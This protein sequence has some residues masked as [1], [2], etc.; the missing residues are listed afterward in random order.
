MAE[1][2]IVIDG[3]EFSFENGETILQ[4]AE[5]NGIFIPT[6]CYLKTGATP[7]GAC[8]VCLV[9][10]KGARSLMAACTVPA[11]PNMVVRT[12]SP[13]V[14]KARRMNLELLLASGQHNCLAQDQ[15]ADSWTDFQLKALKDTEHKDL[16]PAYGIC[17]LQDFAVRYRVRTTHF[18]PSETPF[19][20]ENV[21][22]FIVR[23]FSRCVLCG[24]CV[25]ACNEV[26]VNNAISYGY[27]GSASK[28]VAESDRSLS[29]SDCVF[30]G[31]CVQVCPVGAL[32]PVKDLETETK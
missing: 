21:N 19:P 8:R 20:I 9:E 12:D 32:V 5:R 30:C 25:Q 31:E 17:R 29:E 28:I 7:T 26:Q 16:C 4:V 2:I 13:P 11:G 23:D 14:V 10:V 15:D 24:R 1:N 18:T 22:P 6:L 27:R 3:Q